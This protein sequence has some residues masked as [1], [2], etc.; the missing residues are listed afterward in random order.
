M[1]RSMHQ[2]CS[3]MQQAFFQLQATWKKVSAQ[4]YTKA[5]FNEGVEWQD[6]QPAI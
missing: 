4:G 6:V 5:S 3:Q 2:T 1:H